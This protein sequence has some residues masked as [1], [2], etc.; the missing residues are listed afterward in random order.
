MFLLVD[1]GKGF[2][3]IC[4]RATAKFKCLFREEYNSYIQMVI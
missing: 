3:F 4:E 2:V 1:S